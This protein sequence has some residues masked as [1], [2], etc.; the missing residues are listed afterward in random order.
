PANG[1]RGDTCPALPRTRAEGTRS[2]CGQLSPGP[3]AAVQGGAE[4]ER[5]CLHRLIGSSS[6]L[7]PSLPHIAAGSAILAPHEKIAALAKDR[8]LDGRV[9]AD[10]AGTEARA[11]GVLFCHRTPT[12]EGSGKN[13]ESRPCFL[14]FLYRCFH[15]LVPALGVAEVQ[16]L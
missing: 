14:E 12:A 4:P 2:R 7:F 13:P 11:G 3:I 1:E 6:D 9:A 10:F 15:D 16:P 8:D 5:T